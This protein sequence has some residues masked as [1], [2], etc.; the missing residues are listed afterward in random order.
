MTNEL[1][2][3]VVFDGAEA[4]VIDR[5]REALGGENYDAVIRTLATLGAAIVL[6][7]RQA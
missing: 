3:E 4:S 7:G 2:V 6:G 1:N 5:A